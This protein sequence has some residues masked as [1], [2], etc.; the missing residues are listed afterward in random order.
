MNTHFL[1]DAENRD[2]RSIIEDNN[3][4]GFE[5]FEIEELGSWD[6]NYGLLSDFKY[7]SNASHEFAF[8]TSFSEGLLI[9][10]ITEKATT[11]LVEHLFVEYSISSLLIHND[12]VFLLVEYNTILVYDITIIANPLFMSYYN[13][14]NSIS[15]FR[16]YQETLYLNFGSHISYV[17]F[18]NGANPQKT[19]QYSHPNQIINFEIKN[20]LLILCDPN[21]QF[22]DISVIDNPK[23]ISEYERYTENLV[24]FEDFL[25]IVSYRKPLTILDI[26]NS[27]NPIFVSTISYTNELGLYVN[28]TTITLCNSNSLK[29]INWTDSYNLDI[30]YEI[31]DLQPIS[32]YYSAHVN[33]IFPIEEYII[34][35][36]QHGFTIYDFSLPS[37]PSLVY[38]FTNTGFARDIEMVG[39]IAFVAN[40]HNGLQ[41]INCSDNRKPQLL[42]T[43]ST[44]GFC[45]Q[46]SVYEDVAYLEE[47]EDLVI[48]NITDLTHPFEISRERHWVFW[49]Y[50]C[51]TFLA[52]DNKL[53][54]TRYFRGCLGTIT[55][56]VTVFDITNR[57]NLVMIGEYSDSGLANWY[58]NHD[59]ARTLRRSIGL[60]I[61]DNRLYFCNGHYDLCILDISDES[62][63][64]KIGG[65]HGINVHASS[66]WVE[67]HLAFLGDTTQGVHVL[68]IS[69]TNR[70]KLIQTIC[71]N[72]NTQDWYSG[73]Q[74]LQYSNGYLYTA[75]Y[76]DGLLIFELNEELELQQIGQ[77]Y[78]GGHSC[79][80]V[81]SGNTTFIADEED[82]LEVLQIIG[83]PLNEP[84]LDNQTLKNNIPIFYFAILLPLILGISNNCRKRK[85]RLLRKK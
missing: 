17:D 39:K 12:L 18:S 15:N 59:F 9:F 45:L 77:Y 31:D 54:V 33:S 61:I 24:I 46:V 57:T 78:D 48:I 66:L 43:F 47:D 64:R 14:S 36:K 7:Y 83:L 30:I 22:I 29:I 63:I 50:S 27:Y 67:E 70:I 56:Y 53:Y 21:V 2:N 6:T 8:I 37:N 5:E 52:Q 60:Q 55:N 82:D 4:T 71:T 13:E 3:I 16:L 34:L 11:R 32:N 68:D 65:Y 49:K 73:I 76:D 35:V 23:F 81:V 75:D 74:S 84:F 72:E 85:Y 58:P 38:H 41:I 26:S 20:D 69:K 79:K 10:D 44:E 1:I 25:F 62:D 42:S 19:G 80:V 51:S 28:K 40:G